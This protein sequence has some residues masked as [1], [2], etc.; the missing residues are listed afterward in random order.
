MTDIGQKIRL[1]GVG[2]TNLIKRLLQRFRVFA[3]LSHF[4]R[5]IG[6][7][8]EYLRFFI[9]KVLIG[10]LCLP[11]IPFRVFAVNNEAVLVLAAQLVDHRLER[12]S[13]AFLMFLVLCAGNNLTNNRIVIA[14][15]QMG[16]SIRTVVGIL[17]MNFSCFYVY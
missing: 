12:G 2:V 3:L 6:A 14:Q 17:V 15:H 16:G 7:E 10:E 13:A 8:K 4:F 9:V 1:H 11:H 5:D